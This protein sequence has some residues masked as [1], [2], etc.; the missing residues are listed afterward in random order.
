MNSALIYMLYIYALT[1]KVCGERKDEGEEVK[2]E[3]GRGREN[4]FAEGK[5][6]I[7]QS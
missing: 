3:G 7:D 2:A 6:K 5:I 1:E 4:P